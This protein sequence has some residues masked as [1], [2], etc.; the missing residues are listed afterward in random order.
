[1]VIVAHR[2]PLHDFPGDFFQTLEIIRQF[3]SVH[4]SMHGGS[5]HVGT[6]G[7]GP[8]PESSNL[9]SFNAT[10]TRNC[11]E[12]YIPRAHQ[13]PNATIGCAQGRSRP[14]GNGMKSDKSAV[15]PLV[16]TSSS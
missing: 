7:S 11:D 13:R 12:P 2:K 3:P 4:S 1:R 6:L 10:L 15:E 5:Y 9:L 14:W 16:L 8:P